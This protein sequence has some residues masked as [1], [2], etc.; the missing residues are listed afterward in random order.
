MAF[1]PLIEGPE[2]GEHPNGE[3]LHVESRQGSNVLV[4]SQA[5]AGRRP[6]RSFRPVCG[7][8]YAVDLREGGDWSPVRRIP[9]TWR[10]RR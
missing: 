7:A 9:G 8:R 10:W 4:K 1:E 5:E 6:R 3:A 2:T